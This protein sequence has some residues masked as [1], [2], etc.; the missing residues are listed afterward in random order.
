MGGEVEG[1]LSTLKT[2]AEK[3]TD[4]LDQLEHAWE[5]QTTSETHQELQQV[6]LAHLYKPSV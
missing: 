3:L 2:G 4:R 6:S 5:Q 1:K